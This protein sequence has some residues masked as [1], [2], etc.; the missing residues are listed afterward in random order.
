MAT[1]MTQDEWKQYGEDH[2]GDDQ[3]DWEF[4]C[5]R[6]GHVQSVND[7]MERYPD[8]DRDS[9]RLW[10]NKNCESRVVEESNISCDW[11]LGMID[12][13]YGIE[14]SDTEGTSFAFAD[15]DT[16]PQDGNLLL[17]EGGK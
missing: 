16:D 17:I 5:P 3:D 7:V 9:V 1:T 2:Y 13:Y 10:I 6:C 15:M 12:S 8:R 14:L 11:A 4:V